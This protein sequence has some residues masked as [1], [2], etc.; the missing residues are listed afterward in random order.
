[1]ALPN[2]PPLIQLTIDGERISTR[3]VECSPQ[4]ASEDVASI[5]WEQSQR[6]SDLAAQQRQDLIAVWLTR[7]GMTPEEVMQVQ[8]V[9]PDGTIKW[10]LCRKD[11]P[12]LEPGV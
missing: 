6:A 4:P 8:Q 10:W 11:V 5:L 9:G 7:Y 2:K 12:P 1:M 3:Y